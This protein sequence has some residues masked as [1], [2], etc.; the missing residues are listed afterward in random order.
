MAETAG[1]AGIDVDDDGSDND[2]VT[3]T[4]KQQTLLSNNLE[5]VYH[6]SP[7]LSSPPRPVT[8]AL[9]PFTEPS[10]P[11]HDAIALPIQ[12]FHPSSTS[13]HHTMTDSTMPNVHT[14]SHPLI[15]SKLTQLRLHDLPAKDFR[16]GVK[17]IG[18]VGVGG[19]S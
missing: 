18:W 14:S 5:P 13:L 12:P 19:R 4:F 9:G 15:L 10:Q 11:H 3:F 2:D 6:S 16:E 1:V 17:A 7:S 8:P